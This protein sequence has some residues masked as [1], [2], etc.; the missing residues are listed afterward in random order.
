MS[1]RCLDQPASAPTSDVTEMTGGWFAVGMEPVS[2][3]EESPT[4]SVLSL[5]SQDCSTPKTTASAHMITALIPKSPVTTSA[6]G[7]DFATLANHGA[8]AVRA[9][10]GMVRNTVSH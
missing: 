7:M 10:V 5:P 6:V 3:K 1:Q 9:Q 8:V 2:V 4:A